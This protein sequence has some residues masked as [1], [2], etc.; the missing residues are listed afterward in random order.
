MSILQA[1]GS[2]EL[3]SW[4]A[5]KPGWAGY[6]QK[7]HPSDG[8]GITI[9]IVQKFV[10]LA[11]QRNMI[12]LVVIYPG[13]TSYESYRRS[14]VLHTKAL[15]DQLV[16]LEIPVKDM[17]LDF[18]RYL[19]DRSYSE[20]Q[21]DNGKSFAHFN[22]EGNRLVAELVLAFLNA[23]NGEIAEILVEPRINIELR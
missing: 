15:L 20:L 2:P 1:L 9:G 5:G 12:P 14:G 17:T 13:K 4:I 8:L 3:H 11:R 22:A 6:L 19:N 10:T 21:V 23:Q 7:G 16:A 18:A